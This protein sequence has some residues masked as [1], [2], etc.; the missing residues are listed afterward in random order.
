MMALDFQLLALVVVIRPACA[1]PV[2]ILDGMLCRLSF[3]AG[4]QFFR[5]KKRERCMVSMENRFVIVNVRHLTWGLAIERLQ[6]WTME[7]FFFA[8][9]SSY[10]TGPACTRHLTSRL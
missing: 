7:V 2:H 9:N 1:L 10:T 3:C 5:G 4:Y 8:V 6:V